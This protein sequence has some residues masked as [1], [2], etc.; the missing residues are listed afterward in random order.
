MIESIVL[1][2]LKALSASQSRLAK[3]NGE[4]AVFYQK[5]PDDKSDLWDGAQYPRIDYDISWKDDPE[6]KTVGVM[7]INVWC[8]NESEVPPEDIAA[9]MQDDIDTTFFTDASGSYCATWSQN[10]A[11]V[12]AGNEPQTIG[13]TLQYDM[14]CFPNMSTIE[15][16]PAAGFAAYVKSLY[17]QVVVVGSDDVAEI[18]KPTQD[19]PAFYA[20]LAGESVTSK[21]ILYAYSTFTAQVFGHVIMPSQKDAATMIR[22]I[23]Q[24]LSLDGEFMLPYEQENGTPYIVNRIEYS[25]SSNPLKQGQVRVSGDYRVMR[26][27]SPNSTIDSIHVSSSEADGS[28][29]QKG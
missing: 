8:L 23:C 12:G 9:E 21:Q 11:F 5:A 19:H 7:V 14:W 6:R 26:F 10:Q 17:P 13:I 24:K 20:R 16:D 4:P 3:F 28:A 25:P 29:G 22:E 18:W 1:K 27:Y 2:A 15:P